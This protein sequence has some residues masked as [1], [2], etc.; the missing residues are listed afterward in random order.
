MSTS[1]A[2]RLYSFLPLVY[3]ML[4][5]RQGQPLRALLGVIGEEFDQLHADIGQLYDD[6][7]IETCR[8]EVVPLLG[9]L[10]GIPVAGPEAPLP[11]LRRARVANALRHR[12]RKGRADT[13]GQVIQEACGWSAVVLAGER[14]RQLRQ[15]APRSPL[16]ALPSVD[17]LLSRTQVYPVERSEPWRV[18]EGCYTFHALGLDTPL[19]TLPWREPPR[20]E[21]PGR[22]LPP[23]PFAATGMDA[24][25]RGVLE[26]HDLELRLSGASVPAA[27]FHVHSLRHW[28]RPGPS[29]VGL[30]SGRP[31]LSR[32]TR[33]P[34]LRVRLGEHGPHR[35]LLPHHAYESL[36][37][38]A[39]TLE[40]GLREASSHPAFS[41][42]RVLVTGY[43]L[44]VLPGVPLDGDPVHFAPTEADPDSVH[45]LGLSR[46]EA[47]RVAVLHSRTLPDAAPGE[48][49][50]GVLRLQLGQELPVDLDVPLGGALARLAQEL[51]EQLA[52]REGWHVHAVQD[53]LLV[54]AEAP[55]P[56]AYLRA[57]EA[58]IRE[59]DAASW[60]GM[61]SQVAVD[62]RRGRFA[63]SLGMPTDALRVSWAFGRAADLGAGP[64]PREGGFQPPEPGE[65][66]AEV[67]RSLHPGQTPDGTSRFLELSEALG[68]WRR[69]PTQPDAPR[70]GRIRILDSS[71]Y[72]P[73]P[74]HSELSVSLEPGFLQ[75]E[76]LEGELPSIDGVL[77]VH[78]SGPGVRLRVEG[79]QARGVTL[80]GPLMLEVAHCT[81]LGPLRTSR[82]A[83]AG[84]ELR[85]HTSLL[86]PVHLDLEVG[87][88]ELTGCLVRAEGGNALGGHALGA[89]GPRALLERCTFLG[90]VHVEAAVRARDCL[91]T[92]RVDVERPQESLLEWCAL[93]WSSRHLPR[94]R[95]LL[96]SAPR[97][98]IGPGVIASAPVF[99]SL[100]PA[101]PAYG[102]LADDGPAELRT[103]AGDGGELGAFHDL[104]EE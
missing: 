14:S 43:H 31:I 61:R 68:A 8:E 50:R 94:N 23:L 69:V 6:A 95:C 96:F 83:S 15:E 76:A 11:H 80:H 86:G 33:R 92:H 5:A 44:L 17:I 72:A 25:T 97:E 51:R 84:Q 27:D 36:H 77:A 41:R 88:V 32:A 54:L 21:L 10:V 63:L 81:L 57:Q 22:L 59:A 62:P 48:A 2:D 12:R 71:T 90:P 40:E 1:G 65:W 46:P 9:E 19:Y 35:L 100:S 45:T 64:Y 29:L 18:A 85:L 34:E 93:P 24:E 4:D 89:P 56:L 7:F 66:Y 70:K 42:A 60:L 58:P 73:S 53:V 79:L 3:R 87:H 49:F 39:R 20:R 101:E 28:Q 26:N 13:L 99:V 104:Q 38:L 103:G 55:A 30:R 75:I 102:R 74:G 52:S 16:P 37:M 91:F 78:A 67:G 98:E 47:R 82:E